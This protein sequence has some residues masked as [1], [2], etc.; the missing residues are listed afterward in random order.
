MKTWLLVGG[1]VLLVLGTVILLTPP[2]LVATAAVGNVAMASGGTAVLAGLVEDQRMSQDEI[3]EIVRPEDLHVLEETEL[4]STESSSAASLERS[5]QSGDQP[6]R[7]TGQEAL[8]VLA[9]DD[10]E[11]A[12]S[13][14]EVGL[15]SPRFQVRDTAG[16]ALVLATLR[17]Q[18]PR[19]AYPL[20]VKAIR[21]P[22]Y[23]TRRHGGIALRQLARR[24]DTEGEAAGISAQVQASLRQ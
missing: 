4:P 15:R 24:I 19:R 10:P 14:I 5:L 11:A 13:P 9:N 18:E 20:I 16:E 2:G 6:T 3:D 8:L 1:A 22:Y 21:S 23:Q 7:R 17:L 12:L